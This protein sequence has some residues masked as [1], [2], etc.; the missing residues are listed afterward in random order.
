MKHLVNPEFLFHFAL[1]DNRL[2][3]GPP[4]YCP[5]MRLKVAWLLLFDSVVELVPGVWDAWRGRTTSYCPRYE[6]GIGGARPSYQ[7]S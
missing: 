2:L 6:H 4:G 7:S 3:S 5:E 1:F